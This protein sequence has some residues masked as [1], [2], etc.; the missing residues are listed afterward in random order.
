MIIKSKRRN[1]QTDRDH[2]RDID[3]RAGVKAH[4]ALSIDILSLHRLKT[5]S[6]AAVVRVQLVEIDIRNISA[7]KGLAPKSLGC[8]CTGPICYILIELISLYNQFF[9]AEI[10]AAI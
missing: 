6:K 5:A 10:N 7:K 2:I 4:E 8:L 1:N 9:S 3:H